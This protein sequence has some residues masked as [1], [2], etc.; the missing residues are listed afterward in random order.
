MYLQKVNSK[1]LRKLTYFFDIFERHLRKEH[2]PDPVPDP[3]PKLS[4]ADPV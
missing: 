1:K 2:V 4:C 3:D